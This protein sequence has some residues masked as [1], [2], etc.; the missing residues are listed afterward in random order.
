MFASDKSPKQHTCYTSS[1]FCIP[2]TAIFLPMQGVLYTPIVQPRPHPHAHKLESHNMRAATT[3]CMHALST[4]CCQHPSAL[5]TSISQSTTLW[6]YSV[7]STVQR[8]M[9]RAGS[10]VHEAVVAS[11]MVWM[12]PRWMRERLSEDQSADLK[13]LQYSLDSDNLSVLYSLS[14]FI[15]NNRRQEGQL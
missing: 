13:Q 6:G 10:S 9:L 12:L 4:S 14:A 15:I 5:L 8:I 11:T 3:A 7:D 1:E 2:Y